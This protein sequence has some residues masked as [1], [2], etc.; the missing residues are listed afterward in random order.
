MVALP[1]VADKRSRRRR[2][3]R[4]IIATDTMSRRTPSP[5]KK[6]LDELIEEAPVDAYGEEEQAL[7][8]SVMLEEHLA[9]PFETEL[10]GVAVVVERI[11]LTSSSEIVAVC[12][13]GKH[14]Q[15]VPLLDVPLP[16][17]RAARRR[18]DRRL[19]PLDGRVR[20][21]VDERGL[22]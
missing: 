13:R 2:A 10:L 4:T 15:R 16:K 1:L 11:E 21:V 8:F 6:S 19:P 18:V 5:S 20:P 3:S 9:L 12:R 7:G 22:G 14:R 17:P